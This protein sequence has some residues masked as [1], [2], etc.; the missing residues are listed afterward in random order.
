MTQEEYIIYL[1]HKETDQ[2][3]K[4]LKIFQ[5]INWGQVPQDVHDEAL[6]EC[7]QIEKEI[8]RRLGNKENNT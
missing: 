2:L 7:E 1:T 5:S 4:D 3:L 8:K 6:W